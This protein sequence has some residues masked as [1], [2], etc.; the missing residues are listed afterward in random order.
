MNAD[1]FAL[2]PSV[3]EVLNLSTFEVCI[4]VSTGGFCN[5]LVGQ[6]RCQGFCVLHFREAHLALEGGARPCVLIITYIQ[7][8]TSSS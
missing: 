5:S 8:M 7:V 6:I 2:D 1:M 3:E 4:T